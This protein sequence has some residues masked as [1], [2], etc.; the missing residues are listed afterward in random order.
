[1][2]GQNWGF[3]TYN[4]ER[5]KEDNFEWWRKRFNQMSNYFDAFRIDHI[6]GFFR[7]WSIPMD[8]VEGI[9]GRFVPAIPIDIS[10]FNSN[11][12]WF[13][14]NRYCNPFIS[15]E[16]LQHA[17]G[18]KVQ[19]IKNEFLEYRDERWILKEYV[20]T[21]QKV[22][23]HLGENPD[24]KLRQG[25]FDLISNVILIEEKNSNGQ[26]YHF[27]ISMDRTMSFS[28]LEQ[29]TQQQ[30]KDLYINYF[31]RRQDDFW[32]HQALKKLPALKRSTNMLVCGE[33][34]GMVPHCVPEVMGQLGIL[35]L[36]IERMPK[37]SSKEFFHPNDAPY[38]S[39]VTPSTHD[40][41]NIRGWWEED[42][43]K[44]QKFYNFMLGHYGEAPYFC[45]GWINK[46]IILQ[47]LYSP[48]MLSIFQ[49]QDLLGINEELRRDNPQDERINIPSEPNHYWHYRMHLTLESL[50][51]ENEFNH[52]I[53][54]YIIES[55]RGEA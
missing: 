45:E 43:E 23:Q 18:E 49:L 55:G 4:W 33:D 44:T 39:V 53:N 29:G 40:M 47:H 48:A 21:Q 16:L 42:R 38:L 54:Q 7:I 50:L 14:Y 8:A 6:L 37:D 24:E 27:R 25:L 46:E 3:P 2:K 10:E 36:E 41:S 17:F 5:M 52:E 26:K 11:G 9:L 30:L 15:N 1:V 20:N 22:L 28:Q 13:D 35:S 32:R 34:L 51:Q 12:I 19:E 31:Y